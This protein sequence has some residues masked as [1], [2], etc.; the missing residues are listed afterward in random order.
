MHQ[1]GLRGDNNEQRALLGWGGTARTCCP[2]ICM[3]SWSWFTWSKLC[4]QHLAEFMPQTI[5]VV[6]EAKVRSLILCKCPWWNVCSPG[7]G[8][9]CLKNLTKEEISAFLNLWPDWFDSRFY[10]C[11]CYTVLRT[12]KNTLKPIINYKRVTPP[13]CAGNVAGTGCKSL[14][15]KENMT[16]GTLAM[17]HPSVRQKQVLKTLSV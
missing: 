11:S 15:R 6:L 4:L 9:G 13:D 5:Q 14:P 8:D 1:T 10:V 7:G 2:K 3:K 16:T 12:V 17:N